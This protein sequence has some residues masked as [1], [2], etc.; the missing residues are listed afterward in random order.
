V[1]VPLPFHHGILM[2]ALSSKRQTAIFQLGY[3]PIKDGGEQAY[4]LLNHQNTM[5]KLQ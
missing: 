2:E 1:K 5:Y 3:G 4:L